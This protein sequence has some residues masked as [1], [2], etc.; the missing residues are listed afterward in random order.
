MYSP[1]LWAETDG[2]FAARAGQDAQE[3]LLSEL[4]RLAFQDKAQEDDVF[5]SFAGATKLAQ[6]FV[7]EVLLSFTIETGTA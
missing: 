4:E 1:G 2:K 3:Q 6:T 5:A 7:K